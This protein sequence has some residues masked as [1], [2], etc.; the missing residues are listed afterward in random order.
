M[1]VRLPFGLTV[2]VHKRR[3]AV[4]ERQLARDMVEFA[5]GLPYVSGGYGVTDR[6]RPGLKE[7]R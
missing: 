2:I 4:K 6:F 7:E 1:I 3:W 5:G